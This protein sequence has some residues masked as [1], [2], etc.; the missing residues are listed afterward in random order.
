MK[1]ELDA[2][3]CERYP[4]PLRTAAIF[5]WPRTILAGYSCLIKHLAT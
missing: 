3:L 1:N 5:D 4:H 2:L